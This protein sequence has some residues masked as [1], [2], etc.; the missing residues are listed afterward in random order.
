MSSPLKHKAH[1]S[2]KERQ[3]RYQQFVKSTLVDLN[4][5]EPWLKKQYSHSEAQRSHVS[6]LTHSTVTSD[7]ASKLGRTTHEKWEHAAT[8]LQCQLAETRHSLQGVDCFRGNITYP[9]YIKEQECIEWVSEYEQRKEAKSRKTLFRTRKFSQWINSLPESRF[10]DS[11]PFD[12]KRWFN[13]LLFDWDSHE[14]ANARR[15]KREAEIRLGV[16]ALIELAFEFR[17]GG[18][19]THRAEEDLFLPASPWTATADNV[20]LIDLPSDWLDYLTLLANKQIFSSDLRSFGV[21]TFICEDKVND[22]RAASRQLT[23]DLTSA[24]RQR[25]ALGFEDSMIFGATLVDTDIQFYVSEWIGNIVR[26]AATHKEFDLGVFDEF[27][28]C[29]IFLCKVSELAASD[30]QMVF[31]MWNTDAGKLELKEHARQES[32][33]T[34]WRPIGPPESRQAKKRKGTGGAADDEES[35]Y[36]EDM[37]S[38]ESF[39]YDVDDSMNVLSAYE[40]PVPPGG[41][42]LSEQNLHALD[43]HYTGDK[44]K[45]H[46]PRTEAWAQQSVVSCGHPVDL[47]GMT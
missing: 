10:E 19:H 32:L 41:V 24:Q 31:D 39:G 30:V 2:L 38:S 17:S 34:P 15:E 29:Y 27:L 7:S 36:T 20:C 28:T 13:T 26:V 47:Y 12:I 11:D 42:P 1:P 25:R 8:R 14:T 9:R 46:V 22:F 6:A 16:D 4:V 18:K 35:D 43:A 21:V 5:S 40:E 33:K 37:E 3:G 44:E 23:M 45:K